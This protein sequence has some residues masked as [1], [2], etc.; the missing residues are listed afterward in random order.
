MVAGNESGGEANHFNSPI[1]L[2]F[3]RHGH[4]YVADKSNNRVQRFSLEK[5]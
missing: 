3:D 1:G 5:N 4:L 2:S